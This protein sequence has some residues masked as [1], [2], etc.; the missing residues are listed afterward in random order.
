MGDEGAEALAAVLAG[1]RALETLHVHNNAI[2]PA[3]FRA[4][5]D[6]FK[7]NT[8]LRTLH[9]HDNA[10]GVEGARAV[11]DLLKSSA[12]HALNFGGNA[13]RAEGAAAVAAAV[14]SGA[15]IELLNIDNNSIGNRGAAAFADALRWDPA[16]THLGLYANSIGLDGIRPLADALR[17]NTRLK[18]LNLTGNAGIGDVCATLLAQS[19]EANTT[20][21]ELDLNYTPIGE[22]GG[23]SL[24]EMFEAHPSLVRLEIGAGNE[25][26]PTSFRDGVAA[27]T[28]RKRAGAA[29]VG[30]DGRVPGAAAPKPREDET[31]P[32]PGPDP[33]GAGPIPPSELPT[34]R[35][36][37]KRTRSAF[38][39]EQHEIAVDRSRRLGGG[40]YGDV[41]AATYFHMDVAVKLPRNPFQTP[42]ADA[43]LDPEIARWLDLPP[44]PN[45]APLLG[46]RTG[47]TM[48]VTN[49]FRGG[50]L[51]EYLESRSWDRPA[52]LHLL[53]GAAAG[54][55]FL[56][57]KRVAHS[58]IKPANVLVDVPVGGLP[59]A[60]VS[61]FGLAKARRRVEATGADPAF[62][63]QGEGGGTVRYAP[64]EFFAG[65]EV[66]RAGDVWSFGMMAFEVLS[67]G[68]RP[69]S[70]CQGNAIDVNF[71]IA[72]R[73]RQGTLP[74]PTA[75]FSSSEWSLLTSCWAVNPQE[76]PEMAAVAGE[77]RR[78][79]E[80]GGAF[81]PQ[82]GYAA[83]DLDMST[84]SLSRSFIDP[85][86]AA[87]TDVNRGA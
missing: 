30:G 85:R 75:T 15:P 68:D 1:N 27:A 41:F 3:G 40:A 70:D 80:D 81:Y 49:L 69:Y 39:V 79:M 31:A 4:L 36:E 35:A 20:L 78:M 66:G 52:C 58:D 14:R 42:E 46:Y 11:A 8:T 47:P 59:T 33:I 74:E 9:A 45:I 48:L 10:A 73:V 17:E 25:K 34:P 22:R 65:E 28:A 86:V 21:E 56:H 37:F 82:A 29:A 60:K 43:S 6:A 44:H 2:G 57:A 5:V 53:A 77:L 7:G 84:S 24:L 83:V 19:L 51:R 16:L 54:I 12:L 32:D 18:Y 67:G 76:R 55:A 26:L 23:R 72:R 63:Y 71:E 13:A 87:A 64:P 50:N 38:W 61:D 62:E